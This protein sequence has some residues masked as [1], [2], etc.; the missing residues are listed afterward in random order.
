MQ[1]GTYA[2]VLALGV[3][4]EGRGQLLLGKWIQMD[5]SIPS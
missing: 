1:G 3:L 2:A 4:Q 5:P